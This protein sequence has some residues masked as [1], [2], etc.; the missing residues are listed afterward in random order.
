MKWLKIVLYPPPPSLPLPFPTV[1]AFDLVKKSPLIIR[2][3]DRIK[4]NHSKQLFA[5]RASEQSHT[6]CKLHVST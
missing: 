5:F 1:I 3:V 2:I 4:I 6:F